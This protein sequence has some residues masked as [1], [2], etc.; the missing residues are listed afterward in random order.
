MHSENGG[1][2]S[3]Q[4]IEKRFHHSMTRRMGK[5]TKEYGDEKNEETAE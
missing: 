1:I 5:K 3:P 4:S 2:I